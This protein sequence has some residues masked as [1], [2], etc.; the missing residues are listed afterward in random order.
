MVRVCLR[1]R[2]YRCSKRGNCRVDGRVNER[3]RDAEGIKKRRENVA[4]AL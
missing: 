1:G 2:G 4:R 3:S